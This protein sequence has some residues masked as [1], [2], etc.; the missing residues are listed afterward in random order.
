MIEQVGD[1]PFNSFLFVASLVCGT[2]ALIMVRKLTLI[3]D[4]N[5]N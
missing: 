1:L 5:T 4:S 3:F 2:V